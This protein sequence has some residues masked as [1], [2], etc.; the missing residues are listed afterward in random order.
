MHLPYNDFLVI[1][2]LIDHVTVK[3]VL[4]DGGAS[5]NVISLLVYSAL[6]WEQAQ[7]KP[8][9]TLLVGF[10]SESVTAMGCISLPVTLGEEEH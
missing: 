2:L 4:I 10:A 7:L 3:Q 9:P 8:S 1:V 5:T 6:G